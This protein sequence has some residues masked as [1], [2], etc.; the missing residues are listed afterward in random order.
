M[1]KSLG[2]TSSEFLKEKDVEKKSHFL[3]KPKTCQSEGTG[4]NIS[5][6][7]CRRCVW[8]KTLL[9]LITRQRLNRD[10]ST[11]GKYFFLEVKVK[12]GNKKRFTG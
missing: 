2:V 9:V 12:Q 5:C 1:S 3:G 6:V 8:L 10:L 4:V 7:C 11:E